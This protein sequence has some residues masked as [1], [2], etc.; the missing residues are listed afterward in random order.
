MD[1]QPVL[2]E[3]GQ[4][5]P[6]ATR[7]ILSEQTIPTSANPQDVERVK[8]K[9]GEDLNTAFQYEKYVGDRA[10]F[11]GN[12]ASSAVRYEWDEQMETDAI[13]PRD[14]ILEIQLFGDE[15]EG[16]MGINFDK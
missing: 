9:W 7:D 11:G 14:E 6:T 13:A 12:W 16:N 4:P 1:P 8:G 15:G 2:G 10:E 3:Q 5:V